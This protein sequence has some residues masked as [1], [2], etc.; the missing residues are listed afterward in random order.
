M[1]LDSYLGLGQYLSYLT[2][3]QQMYLYRNIEWLSCNAGKQKVFDELVEYF[4]K[5]RGIAVIVYDGLHD[6]DKLGIDDESDP[7]YIREY[8]DGLK[9]IPD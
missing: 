8:K 6:T 7:V 5:D 3:T 9:L 4:L 2:R 1:Y